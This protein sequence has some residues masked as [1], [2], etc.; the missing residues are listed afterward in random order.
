[1]DATAGTRNE[2][3]GKMSGAI[4]LGILLGVLGTLL[5]LVGLRAWQQAFPSPRPEPQS[6]AQKAN[7]G[8][9]EGVVASRPQWRSAPL[10]RRV[11]RNVRRRHREE[12]QG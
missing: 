10:R 6:P 9:Y 1:M 4:V 12:N 8:Y 2:G 7:E 5:T 3:I 11:Q